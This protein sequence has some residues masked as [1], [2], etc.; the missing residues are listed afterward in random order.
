MQTLSNHSNDYQMMLEQ[1][2]KNQ[3]KQ[4]HKPNKSIKQDSHY[5]NIFPTGNTQTNLITNKSLALYLT[6][7]K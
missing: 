3:I 6:Q 4:C 1:K 2:S 7:A 5:N